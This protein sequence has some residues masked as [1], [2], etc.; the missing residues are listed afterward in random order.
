M[1]GFFIMSEPIKLIV[2]LGNPGRE[3]EATRHNAGFWWVDE[4]A[5]QH[6]ANFKA[7]NKFH[8]LV[9]RATLHGHE[10]HLIKPQTFMNVSGRAVAALALFYKIL[11]DQILVVHDELDLPP[12]SAK[13]KL[14]G[15][16]GGHNG[17][18]DIIAQ[19]GTRD[20]W[21]LRVG[22]GHPGDR[23]EVV[24]FVLNAPRKE[25]QVLIDAALQRAQ[26]VAASIIEGKMEAAMLKLHS[27]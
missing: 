10:V 7:D 5:R 17:L 18:K 6:N 12:G 22:I 14:G 1:A 21:R 19:L 23:A 26:D 8:G 25:E 20:F 27:N 16:H 15:G 24:N 11:P 4:L 2:G 3:Y 13:L 9:A